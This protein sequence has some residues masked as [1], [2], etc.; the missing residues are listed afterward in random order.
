[1]KDLYFETFFKSSQEYY[2][3]KLKQFQE[4]KRISFN[5]PAL[6]FGCFW[7]IYRKMYKQALFLFAIIMV[8]SVLEQVLYRVFYP[9]NLELFQLIQISVNIA[10]GLFSGFFGNWIYINHANRK[11]NTLVQ[12]N[13]D[14]QVLLEKLSKSGGTSYAAHIVAA[15]FLGLLIIINK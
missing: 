15:I 5:L 13:S 4:G 12:S 11:V 14:E 10:F 9:Y 7:F 2:L 8:L 1:M 3:R 6:L